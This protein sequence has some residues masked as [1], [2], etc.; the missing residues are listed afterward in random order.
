LKLKIRREKKIKMDNHSH[1]KKFGI[2]IILNIVITIAEYI[3]GIFSG[4]L[5]LISDA[6][7]N[8]SDVL[9]LILGYFGEKISDKESTKKHTFGFKRFEI[10][11]ALINSLSLWA[12]GIFIIYEA[13]S[14]LKTTESISIG[15]MIGIAFIGLFGNLFS[16][17]VLNK[18]KDESLNMKAAYTHLFYDTISSI[19]VIISGIV[20]YFTGWVILDLLI[21]IFI[22]LMIFY[23]GFE[24][25]KK[26]IHIFMQG[27][28]EG[29]EFDEV[30]QTILNINGVESLHNLHIWSIDSDE[31]FLSGHICINKKKSNSKKIL[32]EINELILEKYH[33]ENSAI[34]IEEDDFCK[35]NNKQNI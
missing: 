13:I 11:T 27:T 35:F 9:S 10:F 18:E 15:L 21:S 26:S 3:G 32:E 23:S 34:Q 5:A 24:I 29:I 8:L 12:I 28:P 20:I 4:S 31:I 25:I 17:L 2:T 1:T 30:Y 16:I 7:H 6:G 33:I 14:R 19:A 22:S